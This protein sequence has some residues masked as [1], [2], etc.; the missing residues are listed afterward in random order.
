MIDCENE[1]Y[2]RIVTHLR[3]SF[4]GSVNVASEYV[5]SPSAFPHVSIVMMDNSLME[6]TIDSGD[7]EVSV[8]M[9][10]INVYS[11]K[12]KG[13][14]SECKE[15]ISIIDDFLRPLN[16]RRISLTP[17]PNMEDASI[18]RMV[19]RYRVTTDGTYFYGR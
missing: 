13:K 6:S 9:F 2:S 18:Y 1:V 11:N 12:G 16:F 19:A 17:V 8:T 7:H 5:K 3:E 14:K 10:E 4:T 15:I